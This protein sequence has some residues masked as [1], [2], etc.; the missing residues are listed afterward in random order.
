MNIRTGPECFFSVFL[1]VLDILL[2]L[3]V[4]ANLHVLCCVF[5]LIPFAF[6]GCLLS[7]T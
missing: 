1:F 3:F 5:F 4:S 2:L 6:F 7:S